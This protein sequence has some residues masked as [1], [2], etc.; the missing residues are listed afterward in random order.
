MPTM[1]TGPVDESA[2]LARLRAGEDAAFE[3]F[4]REYSPRCLAV[5]RR[6]FPSDDDAQDALQD[7]FLSAFKAL[8][9]FEGG[10]KLSTWLHRILVNACLMKL[11]SRKARP[12]RSIE[13]FQ[14]AFK[15]DGHHRDRVEEWRGNERLESDEARRMVRAAIE[16]LPESFRTVLVLRDIEGL[17]TEAAAREL[18]LSESAVKTRLHRARLALRTLLDPYMC[19]GAEP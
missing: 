16:Q 8:G 14:P 13:E 17:D 12:E 10:S 18:G 2:L 7:A 11:R 6:F 15:E 1:T 5:A 9:K 4:V 3:V 19:G